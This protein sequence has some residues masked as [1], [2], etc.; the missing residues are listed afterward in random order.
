MYCIG[1]DKQWA[2]YSDYFGAPFQWWED[3]GLSC[4]CLFYQ[5]CLFILKL[6]I[7]LFH[8]AFPCPMTYFF[9]NS[10]IRWWCDIVHR[11]LDWFY[12]ITLCQHN[13]M[14]MQYRNLKILSEISILEKILLGIS[15]LLQ[16][17]ISYLHD[18]LK[19]ILMNINFLL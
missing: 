3:F 9:W 18:T 6:S 14:S 10:H 19:C 2:L 8:M 4:K 15:L 5:L 16:V 11:Q 17:G 13:L 12:F 1:F 7:T